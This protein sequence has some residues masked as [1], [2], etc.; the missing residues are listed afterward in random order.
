MNNQNKKNNKKFLIKNI[1]HSIL[2]NIYKFL[3]K[4]Q[5]NLKMIVF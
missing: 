5:N 2:K 3:L 4:I 1:F